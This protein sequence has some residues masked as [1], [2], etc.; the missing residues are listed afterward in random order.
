MR[1]EKKMQDMGSAY[2]KKERCG[3]TTGYFTWEWL[4]PLIEKAPE[5]AFHLAEARV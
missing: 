5:G 1:D 4:K 3:F 2:A